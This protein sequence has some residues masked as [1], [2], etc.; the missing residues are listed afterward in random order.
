MSFFDFNQPAGM[1]M[2]P[3]SRWIIL[4]EPIPWD[5]PE[6]MYAELFKSKT[7]IFRQLSIKREK[8]LSIE[9]SMF[10]GFF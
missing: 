1:H 10:R 6:L 3:E 2:N 8:P 7:G 9:K 5:D 4:A